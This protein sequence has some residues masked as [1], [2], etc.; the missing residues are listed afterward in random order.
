MPKAKKS[1]F[2][3]SRKKPKARNPLPGEVR[4]RKISRLAES[5]AQYGTGLR[6]VELFAGVGGF[7]VGL[8]V[9]NEQLKTSAFSVVWSSQWEPSTKRQHASEVYEAR[10]GSDNHS[11]EDIAVAVK[12][13]KLP[14]KFELLVGGF[15]CQDYSVARTLNQAAG[16][17]GKKG[18][19]WWEIRNIL[20]TYKPPFGLFENV[21]RLIKSPAKQRG[22]DFAVMLSSLYAL[23]YN[24]E[25]RVVN[26]AE[27]GF[28][29]RRKRIFILVYR[30]DMPL[31]RLAAEYQATWLTGSGVLAEALPCRARDADLIGSVHRDYRLSKDLA[32]IT[33]TFN[34]GNASHTPFEDAGMLVGDAVH[35]LRTVPEYRGPRKVLG[36]ILLP[37]QNVPEEFFISESDLPKWKYLKGAKSLERKKANGVIYTYDEGPIAFPDAL[38]RPSRTIITGEGGSTPSRFKHVVK[39]A[40]GRW[41]RLTPVELERLS[42]FPD[43]HTALEGITD[44]KRAFFMGNALVT[45][46]VTRIGVALFRRVSRADG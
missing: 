15:P 25:W 12:E 10:F 28:P 46:V 41:R 32:E 26:S 24:A 3:Y 17:A 8:N 33:E 11:N 19:L 7:R 6:V 39:L 42:G 34:S 29:Q 37:T 20:Q 16:I 4:K 30:A 45:G 2:S 13:R 5:A 31:A 21:D 18:V 14:E 27:Y 38:D 9:A 44:A 36:D 22:R 23:G 1:G 40:D 43:N 35:T